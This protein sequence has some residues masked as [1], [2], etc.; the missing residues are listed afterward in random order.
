MLAIGIAGASINLAGDMLMG[1]GARDASLTG[2]EGYVSQYLTIADWRMFWSALL[3]LIGVPVSLVG[4][5]GIYKLIKPYSKKYARL[6]GVGIFGGFTFGGAGVHVSSVASAFFYKYMTA[7][8]SETALATSIQFVCY[9]SVPLYIAL[10][11]CVLIQSYAHIRALA[12]GLTPYPRWCWLCSLPVGALLVSLVS[13][14]GNYALVNAIMVGVFSLGNIWTQSWHLILLD[15]AKGV[16]N[17]NAP[18][19]G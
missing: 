13:L 14:F 3:G 16:Y 18:Y 6:Y 11:I 10:L 12:T 8:S 15:K 9:F 17:P 7:A 5:I 19:D 4:H 1:W 2:V